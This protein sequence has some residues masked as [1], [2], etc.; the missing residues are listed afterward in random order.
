MNLGKLGDVAVGAAGD[1]AGSVVDP[2]AGAV[3]LRSAVTPRAVVM[4]A[5]GLFL[6][7][8]LA[9]SRRHH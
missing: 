1:V 2:K 3:R 6:G 4:L 8:L 5:A 7:Y 9:R